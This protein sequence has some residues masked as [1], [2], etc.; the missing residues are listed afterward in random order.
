MSQNNSPNLAGWAAIITAIA[1]LITA[2]GF[3]NFFPD[4][5]KQYLPQEK[6]LPKAKNN[7]STSSNTNKEEP[8][9]SIPNVGDNPVPLPGSDKNPIDWDDTALEDKKNKEDAEA[10]SGGSQEV[11]EVQNKTKY[12][13]FYTVDGEKQYNGTH[14]P[15]S[16]WQWAAYNGGIIKF[17][18]N[19]R[20]GKVQWKT[21][22]LK[23][24]RIYAFKENKRT[25]IPYDVDLYDVGPL[26]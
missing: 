22:N 12:D 16:F 25:K 8:K 17:D 13:I 6:P 7:N 19:M 11:F 23:D 3:P 21:Y 15:D 10:I 5:V 14:S 2:I 24:G 4:L 20:K 9:P 26:W 1:A 18:L